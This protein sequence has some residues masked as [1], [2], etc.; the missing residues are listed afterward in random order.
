MLILTRSAG[1]TI[2]INDDIVITILGVNG[3]QVRIGIAAPQEVAVHRDEVYQR[4]QHQKQKH[5]SD[6]VY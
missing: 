6:S 1:E 2:R 3:R 5:V 4:I